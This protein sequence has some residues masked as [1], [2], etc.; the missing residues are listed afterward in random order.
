MRVSHTTLR[1]LAAAVWYAGAGVLIW[2]GA[3]RFL[4]AA[5][6]LGSPAWPA[7][8]ALL[9]L[10]LG[11][12]QGRT[13]FRR[14]CVRNL[15]R[16]RQLE[17]PRAWQFFRPR[18][19]LALAAMVGGAAALSVVAGTGPAAAVAVAGVDW[20]IGFSLLVS[21]PAFWRRGSSAWASAA[22]ETAPGS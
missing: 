14:A 19:F 13:V 3:Q 10:G 2:K 15:R 22:E 4:E 5:A 12:I 20:L 1:L 17:S 16:I 6:A 9:G 18:F 7:T 8:A 11:A 21:S